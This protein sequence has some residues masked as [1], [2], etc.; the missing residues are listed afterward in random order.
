MIAIKSESPDPMVYGRIQPQAIDAEEA[1]L[2]AVLTISDSINSVA[3]MLTVDD[4]YLETNRNIFEAILSLHS[5]AHSVD[6]VTVL[7]ETKAMGFQVGAMQLAELTNKVASAAHTESHCRIIKEQS[8][9][10]QLIT[11]MT[12][13]VKGAFDEMQDPFELLNS[14]EL[15]CSKI[16]G[17][18]TKGRKATKQEIIDEMIRRMVKS[19]TNGIAMTG[20]HELDDLLGKGEPGEVIL[21]AARPGMG[22]S[23]MANT[24]V[25]RIGFILQKK[26]KLWGLEMTNVQSMRRLVSNLAQVEY[27]DL[28]T[29]NVDLD[30]LNPWIKQI[31]GSSL[32]FDDQAGVTA[33]E[34]RSGLISEQK[35]RGLDF[36]II[37][38]GRLIAH[39]N[40]KNTTD[41]SEIGKTTRLLKQTAKDLNIPLLLLWQLNRDVEKRAGCIPRLSDLRDG[42]SLEE[43]ADKIIFLYRPEYYNIDSYRDYHTTKNLAIAMVAKNRDG[44]LGEAPM[45]F[46]PWYMRFDPWSTSS[47]P[48]TK[49]LMP[50]PKATSEIPF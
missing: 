26:I 18:I 5:K 17:S 3:A 37:D 34:I 32:E 15:L 1:V 12:N 27:N 29:G 25:K 4:F 45:T 46:N 33:M 23:M 48:N 47:L 6:M 36:A 9:R 28:K 31:L 38:H 39:M 24:I 7:K 49:D 8:I 10:R 40:Q 42:G 14:V 41:A 30:K 11:E 13:G 2:G 50:T 16:K 43:D 35:A 21:L 19:E 44:E 20:I 22:K